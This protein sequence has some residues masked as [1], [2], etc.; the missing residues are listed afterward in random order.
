LIKLLEHDEAVNDMKIIQYE[1]AG[2]EEE[3]IPRDRLQN[4]RT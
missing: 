1:G 2:H 4:D 3:K